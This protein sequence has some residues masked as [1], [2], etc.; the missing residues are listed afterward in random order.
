MGISKK[1]KEEKF[2]YVIAKGATYTQTAN[3]HPVVLMPDN[4]GPPKS[5]PG[6]IDFRKPRRRRPY[7]TLRRHRT[8][9]DLT[10]QVIVYFDPD[11]S[12]RCK[13][14]GGGGTTAGYGGGGDEQSSAG[15]KSVDVNRKGRPKGSK[16]KSPISSSSP[17]L[18]GSFNYRSQKRSLT[19]TFAGP[20][21]CKSCDR[22]FDG[23]PVAHCLEHHRSVCPIC[24]RTYRPPLNTHIK[25]HGTRHVLLTVTC[26]ECFVCKEKFGNA[27]TMAEHLRAEHRDVTAAAECSLC[28]DTTTAFATAEAAVDHLVD[29]HCPR[30]KFSH[31]TV[32][33]CRV[34]LA[35]FKSQINVLRHAC[36]KI[37]SPHCAQ[38]G[39]TFPSKMRYAFHLQFHEHPKW[40]TMHLHCDLCLAEFDD[41]YQLYDHIRFRHEL[42]DKAVCEVCGR[43]FK[44]SMGLN[45]HRRYHNGSRDFACG[46]CDKSFLNK[47]TLREHEISHMDVKPFQCHICGQYLS[48]ASRLRSHV[49]THR[50]AESTDQLCY[51]CGQCGYVAPNPTAVAEH[52]G[53]QHCDDTANNECYAL[54]LSSVVKC[55]YCDSTYLSS[56]H[57]NSH[58]EA[59]HAG[60]GVGNAEPFICVVCSSTFSTYSR[61]TTHKLTHGINMESTCG[62]PVQQ[63]QPEPDDLNQPGDFLEDTVSDRFEIPQFFSCEYC[64]KMC[65]HY[66]YFC[67]HRRLKHPPGVQTHTCERCSVDF[68][69]SWRLSYH[70]KTVHGQQADE[71]PA[72]KFNCTVC[73]RQFVK[74]GALNLH[75]TRT[76]I[77]VVGDVCKYLCHLCGKFFSSEFSLR[78][79]VKTHELAVGGVL[80]PA[81]VTLLGGCIGNDDRSLVDN[82]SYRSEPSAM[83]PPQTVHIRQ[84]HRRRTYRKP[85]ATAAAAAACLTSPV[86]KSCPY[87]TLTTDD[88]AAFIEHVNGHIGYCNPVLP[89]GTVCELCEASFGD[90]T[91]LKYHLDD[92]VNANQAIL[93]QA[94]YSPFLSSAA[95]DVHVAK[96]CPST[97]MLVDCAPTGAAVPP[98]V[99]FVPSEVKSVS[100]STPPEVKSVSPSTPPEVKS[101]SPSTPPEVKPV[102]PFTPPEVKSVSLST[103]PQVKSVS[104][105]TPL[106]VKSVS[107][108][109][110]LEVESV[111][112]STQPPDVKF[113]GLSDT[114]QSDAR[115]ALI[116]DCSEIF[117]GCKGITNDRSSLQ[118]SA[119]FPIEPNADNNG[120][121]EFS[122][123]DELLSIMSTP[124]TLVALDSID[125]QPPEDMSLDAIFDS[126]STNI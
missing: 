5:C 42:H 95:R 70:R 109:T 2:E 58:R 71:K 78:A 40:A 110:P 123:L 26:Y 43:T 19:Y 117:G 14:V 61:L 57:L 9:F 107:T 87:C 46:S 29:A 106:E 99:E 49:K 47:S 53:K 125:Y 6:K 51:C 27:Q 105:H 66:T 72:E 65:L 56:V 103:P 115:P 75:K 35:G 80:A 97:T 36:N 113:V 124:R 104:P 54:Q 79:H 81:Q 77:D 112:T 41:E 91:Q 83:A 120:S 68:K 34:C 21:K 13:V 76:H 122:V 7:A 62:A 12:G 33:R 48:R 121:L 63:Q 38:C 98:R 23:D 45:I 74:I 39:K 24:G 108:S 101:V 60:G 31:P 92:H 50:A 114:P 119:E 16:N 55:E 37:K 32:Y 28:G 8:S 94:C 85:I 52:I 93:C 89:A 17:S 84:N 73:S 10:N 67:L 126:I 1:K 64:S 82:H 25:S 100:P 116:V 20:V 59:A 86:K 90:A 88:E 15:Q 111:S 4:V 3:G 44:S 18:S 96:E 118:K 102:S 11:G 69:T 22:T 30:K